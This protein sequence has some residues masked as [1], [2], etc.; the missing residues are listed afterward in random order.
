MFSKK[1]G[2]LTAGAVMLGSFYTAAPAL[3]APLPA[4]TALTSAFCGTTVSK[5]SLHISPAQVDT[6]EALARE[7][8][9]L[10]VIAKGE[11]G[12]TASVAVFKIVQ[13]EDID[14]PIVK[15]TKS[16]QAVADAQGVATIKVTL[17][18]MG[19]ERT[20]AGGFFVGFDDLTSAS[21]GQDSVATDLFAIYSKN[22]AI[23]GSTGGIG[24]NR[25]LVVEILFGIPGHKVKA[26]A[27][28]N[29][30]WVDLGATPTSAKA[31]TAVLDAKG[32]ADL[33]VAAPSGTP[34]GKYPIRLVNL[35]TGIKGPKLGNLTVGYK[36]TE[37]EKPGKDKPGK[38]KPGTPGK[39]K[40]SKP[41]NGGRPTLP[42]TGN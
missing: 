8:T 42:N 3:A 11:P 7:G 10:T 34:K 32:S 26:Q 13:P 21:F 16:F 28:I 23:V 24:T 29:G 40:P 38:D 22:P 17:P 15:V 14:S 1:L 41:G 18:V 37:K 27:L 35:T 20:G 6:D 2:A 39:D 33:Q 36:E 25:P 31:N 5:C 9:T 12:K 30:S 4:T 19:A